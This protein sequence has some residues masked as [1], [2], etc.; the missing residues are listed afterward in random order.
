MNEIKADSTHFKTNMEREK[1]MR[2]ADSNHKPYVQKCEMS[3]L[4]VFTL[5]KSSSSAAAAAMLIKTN[6]VW[7]AQWNW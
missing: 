6:I 2:F 3:L 5:Y 1:K 7:Y 4:T